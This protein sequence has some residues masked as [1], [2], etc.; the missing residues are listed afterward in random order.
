MPAKENEL[1]IDRTFDAPRDL[2]WKAWTEP[3][4]I[5][6]WLAP[7]GFTI[8]MA[9]GDLRNGGKWR[10]SM[11]T[12]DGHELRLSGVYREVKPPERLVFTHAW[13]DPNGN[14]GPETLVEVT[15][16]ARGDKTDMHFSQSGFKSTEDRDNHSDGW[17]Q[18]FDRLAE[19][20]NT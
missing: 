7:R 12:P 20:L 4:Q 5:K 11:V 16:T 19:L 18:C 6:Q 10:Q 8:P 9:E 14:P 15:F 3:D 2:V 17:G 13:D 1:V